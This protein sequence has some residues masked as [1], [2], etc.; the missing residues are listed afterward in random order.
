[1]KIWHICPAAMMI[2]LC[3]SSITSG[4]NLIPDPSFEQPQEKNKF[5]HVFA[6]WSGWIYEGECEFRV[7]DLART[8]KHSLLI[9]GGR[10]PKIRA[11]PS[12][13]TLTPGRYRTTA[14]I[15]GLDIGTGAW[16]QTTEFMFEGKYIPL[17]KNGTFGWSKLTYVGEV[18]EMR[19]F[20]HPSFGLMAPGYLWV[21]DVSLEKVGEDVPLTPEPVIENEE[22]AISPPG[23][24]VEGA[25]HCPECGYRNMP[26]WGS[27]YACGSRIVEKKASLAGDTVKLITSFE[28]KNPFG[29]GTIVTEHA[30]D[31][32]KA[33]RIDM[34]YVSMDAAQD[35]SGFDLIQ[36]D[37][38]TDAT[39]PLHIYFEVRDKATTGYWTRVNYNT[40]VPPGSSTLNIPTALYVGEKSRPGRPLMLNAITRMVFSVGEKP[41]APFY[42]D[43]VRLVRD[44]EAQQVGFDGLHAFDLGTATSPVMEGF[45]PLTDSK[46]YSRFRG[47]GWKNAHFWR[48]FDALQPD[49]L[50][51]DFIC[52]EKGGL[53]IDVPNGKY[54]VFVNMDSPSGFW[55]EVQVYTERSL[56]VEGIKYTD[57][58]DLRS[59]KDRYYRFWNTDDLPTEDTFT[60][61]Q[62]PYFDEKNIEVEVNDEQL[63][64]EFDG[65]NWACSVSTI[66]AYPDTKA[67]EGKRFLDFLKTRRRFHYDNYFKR[68][69]HTPSGQ[70]D[71]TDVEQKRG[72]L[73]FTRDWMSDVYYNDGPKEGE[74]IEKLTASAFAGEQEPI[75]VSVLPSRDLGNMTVKVSDLRGPGM[76]PAQSIDVGHVQ[77]RLSRVTMEGSVYTIAPRLIQPKNSIDMPKGITRTFWVNVKTPA[78]TAAG[79]YK[80]EMHITWERGGSLVVP[81]EFTVRKGT[82]DPVDIP[83]GP[84]GHTINLPW[85]GAEVGDWNDAMA[86]KSLRKLRDYGFTTC[87]GLPVVSFKGFQD[88][89]P[90]IDYSVADAQMKRLKE[91]GFSMPVISYCQFHGLDTYFKD[92]GAMNR[93]GFTDYSEFLKTLFGAIQ[94]HANEAGWLPVYWNLGDEPIG[95]SLDKSAENAEAYRKAF[96]QGPPFFTAASS[97]KGS[98]KTDPHFRLSKALHVADWNLHD[99]ESANLI[100]EAGSDWAFYN[101]GNRWTYGIYMY[102]AAKQFGMK[103]RV[104]WHWNVVAGD[105][106][107]A[108]DC[109]EDDYAWCNSS[110]EGD[111]I[112]AISFVRLREGLDDYR[113]M[114]TL[115]RLAKEHAG[116]PAAQSAEK[117]MS[118]ILGAFRLGERTLKGW[119]NFD[120]VRG[121]LDDAIEALRP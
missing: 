60:K 76:I 44:T 115:A 110:P 109:R 92:E 29:G 22:K 71:M 18:K 43:N 100:H 55:G 12:N 114:I 17:S 63:N 52:V 53:A 77:Y 112:P 13:L 59:F 68:V 37:V 23:E 8:G 6:R 90:V 86:L 21:D 5:G 65:Q 41:E 56:I 118:K 48:S 91:A 96:P 74:R 57:K 4:E 27:C 116:T 19:A 83:A 25:A 34:N 38:H 40:V 75:T 73:V 93:A 119:E 88:G 42:I 33:L 32:K 10:A 104:S 67:E 15:R 94:K 9:F 102:K 105:P 120:S 14:F 87:S 58:R 107:Y 108:L 49:P 46:T 30:T 95:D 39:N 50:Y 101:G 1:M 26:S 24:V 80:G 35:W 98:D 97:F 69:L 45:S 20:G 62:D 72:F 47:F 103:F 89:V 64:I 79:A 51:Q 113:R 82:L 11:S 3:N 81:I 31:G 54:H 2:C 28:D 106:Y 16:K 84:W 121:Q 117:L 70:D 61:Y 36:A 66:V 99:E 85:H 78:D 111:L 7:S